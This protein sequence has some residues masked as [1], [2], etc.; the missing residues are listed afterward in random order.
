MDLLSIQ[1]RG[2]QS[3]G[4]TIPIPCQNG[5]QDSNKRVDTIFNSPMCEKP[6]PL[7]KQVEDD[8]DIR[9][10]KRHEELIFIGTYIN[11][12]SQIM[13]TLCQQK[14]S[15]FF[16]LVRVVDLILLG[17]RL[18][19]CCGIIVC[20]TTNRDQI[21]IKFD[22]KEP[23]LLLLRVYLASL[24]P[25]HSWWDQFEGFEGDYLLLV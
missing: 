3:L 19:H 11:S 24:R 4:D 2:A 23:F 8:M 6:Y 20:Q 13:C 5:S 21:L 18:R 7:N 15:R 12:Q 17:L 14:I 22:M 25:T 1:T 9:S 16:V 10:E